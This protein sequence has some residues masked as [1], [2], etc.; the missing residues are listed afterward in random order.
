MGGAVVGHG[1]SLGLRARLSELPGPG[2]DRLADAYYGANYERLR[3]IKR[4]YDP[5]GLFRFAEQSL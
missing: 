1:A 4:A 5:D 2:P 3:R